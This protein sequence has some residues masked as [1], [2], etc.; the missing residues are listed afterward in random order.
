MNYQDIKKLVNDDECSKIIYFLK[1]TP[2]LVSYTNGEFKYTKIAI[3][4][5]FKIVDRCFTRLSIIFF[6]FMAILS[7]ALFA[8][9]DKGISITGFVFLVLSSVLL[10]FQIK[11]QSYDQ[12]VKNLVEP[13]HNN[14]L[15]PTAVSGG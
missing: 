14:A 7:W 15:Q 10:A 2:G 9:G 4:K 12:M 13:E 1:R 5:F 11:E 6:S 8:F 3:N